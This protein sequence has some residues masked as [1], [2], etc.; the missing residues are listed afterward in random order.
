MK[1]NLGRTNNRRFYEI[2]YSRILKRLRQSLENEDKI[3]IEVNESYTSKCDALAL[4]P[5][6]KH[7][8]YSGF[9][10]GR[11]FQSCA[12]D[13]KKRKLIHSDL[14][15]AINIMRKKYQLKEIKGKNI[16]NPIKQKI[17]IFNV[18]FIYFR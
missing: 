7:E 9:R 8:K 6:E 17:E 16:F 13:A 14:N 12:E 4:E 3:L 18:F 11:L 5:I 15:G 10:M 2:P 1:V